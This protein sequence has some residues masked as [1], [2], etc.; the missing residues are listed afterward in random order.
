MFRLIKSVFGTN[1]KQAAA[2]K[3][4]LTLI[5]TL[6]AISIFTLGISGF[7]MLLVQEWKSN[8]YTIEMGRSSMIVSQGVNK[9]MDYIRGAR[10][11]DNGG[12]PIQS[13]DSNDLVIFS[14]YDSDGVTERLHFYKNGT[15]VMMGITDPTNT[16]PKTYPSGDQSVKTIASFI[17]NTA[18]DPVFAYY[19]TNYTGNVSTP[20][21][22]TPAI[23]A[24]VR[25]VKIRLKV[26]IDVNRAPDNIEM[27]TYVEMRNLNDYDR[28]K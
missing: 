6:I 28:I 17:V 8:K 20:P 15:N 1:R 25:L 16:M 27:Q 10:Q 13:A 14:D 3:P 23:I 18:S 12:Y 26:N 9:M 19:D 24:N 4:G 2:G 11:S 5:E 21:L 22:A 7:S